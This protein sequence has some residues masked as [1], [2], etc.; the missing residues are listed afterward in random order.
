LQKLAVVDEETNKHLMNENFS[1]TR[2][3]LMN[4]QEIFL[5]ELGLKSVDKS[6]LSQEFDKISQH[7]KSFENI[8]TELQQQSD[9][10]LT[11]DQ[12]SLVSQVNCESKDNEVQKLK[13]IIAAQNDEIAQLK[14]RAIDFYEKPKNV[15]E[16]KN[17][18]NSEITKVEINGK[19]YII[20]QIKCQEA[21]CSRVSFLIN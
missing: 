1:L 6:T 5:K 9:M 7:Q 19:T 16:S 10:S 3:E 20:T 8:Y 15:D 14:Q 18:Q 4:H 12:G 21:G 2:S 17:I 11:F 13:N